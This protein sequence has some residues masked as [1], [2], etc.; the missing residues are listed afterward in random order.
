MVMALPILRGQCSRNIV[1]GVEDNAEQMGV[2][3]D[4]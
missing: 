4:H 1:N 3:T 2:A